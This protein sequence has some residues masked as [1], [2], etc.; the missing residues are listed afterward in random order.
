[1]RGRFL[2]AIAV[3]T[4]LATWLLLS[5]HAAA[6]TQPP[7]NKVSPLP[8]TKNPYIPQTPRPEAPPLVPEHNPVPA[9]AVPGTP[10]PDRD[11]LPPID[12]LTP[13]VQKEPLPP[14]DPLSPLV[15]K[16]PLR[17]RTVPGLP[18]D[19]Q[20]LPVVRRDKGDPIPLDEGHMLAGLKSAHLNPQDVKS[21]DV[22]NVLQANLLNGERVRALLWALEHNEQAWQ[23]AQALTEGL[24]ARS[25]L[26]DLQHV[27]G[28]VN[29]KVYVTRLVPR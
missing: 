3:L 16:E 11:P 15:N 21:R 10:L 23:E 6:Q 17:P 18:T 12:P 9:R 4:V 22:I 28:V 1:M 8:P 13:L 7:D 27:V 2:T 29:G 25:F 26:T 5:A 14:S 19:R 20:S 24:R